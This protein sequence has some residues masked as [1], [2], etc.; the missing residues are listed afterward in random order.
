MST[1]GFRYVLTTTNRWYLLHSPPP[2]PHEPRKD[3]RAPSPIAHMVRFVTPKVLR[4]W[5]L[6]TL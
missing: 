4:G 6:R 1:D 2:S 3:C 5:D